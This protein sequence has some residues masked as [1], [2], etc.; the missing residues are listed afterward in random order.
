M[1]DDDYEKLRLERELEQLKRERDADR[2]SRWIV[3]FLAIWFLPLFGMDLVQGTDFPKTGGP[4]WPFF[5]QMTISGMWF[6]GVPLATF[7]YRKFMH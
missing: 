4:N 5:G 2:N 1:S 3:W 7:L 6:L